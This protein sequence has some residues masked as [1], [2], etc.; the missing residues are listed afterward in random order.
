MGEVASVV[1]GDN[2]IKV[3]EENMADLEILREYAA[4]R[5]VLQIFN[6]SSGE[7]KNGQDGS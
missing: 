1:P 3:S 2:E 6:E 4:Q 7:K 5:F